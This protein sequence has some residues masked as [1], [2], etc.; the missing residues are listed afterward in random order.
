MNLNLRRG[1]EVSGQRKTRDDGLGN[2]TGLIE[3]KDKKLGNYSCANVVG[4]YCAV[5]VCLCQLLTTG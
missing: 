5:S 1:S 2:D 4:K 3:E